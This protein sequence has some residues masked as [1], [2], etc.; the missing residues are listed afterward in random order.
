[1]TFNLFTLNEQSDGTPFALKGAPPKAIDAHVNAPV[2][3][4]V[5]D[6]KNSAITQRDDHGSLGTRTH[7]VRLYL[8]DHPIVDDGYSKLQA[9]QRQQRNDQQ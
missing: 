5:I 2:L 7:G 6:G 4:K 9:T 8:L 3:N 1:M